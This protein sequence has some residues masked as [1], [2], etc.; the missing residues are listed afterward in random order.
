MDLLVKKEVTTYGEPTGIIIDE[1]LAISE[2]FQY[3]IAF[4]NLKE[5]YVAETIE[6]DSELKDANIQGAMSKIKVTHFHFSPF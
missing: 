2:R 4:D 3:T 5:K 1:S 6:T